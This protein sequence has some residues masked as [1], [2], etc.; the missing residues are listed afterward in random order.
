MMNRVY[1]LLL[2]ITIVACT[3]SEQNKVAIQGPIGDSAM[4][5]SAHPIATQ[6]GLDI[7]RKGGNAVDAAIATQFA[8][9]IVFPEAGNIGGGGF[10]IYREAKGNVYALDYREKPQRSRSSRFRC[11]RFC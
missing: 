2:A 5:V 4:V 3:S 1:I 11:A 9:A 10:M 8:L 6:I 7:L